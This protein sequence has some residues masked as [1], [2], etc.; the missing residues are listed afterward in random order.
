MGTAGPVSTA[1]GAESEMPQIVAASIY[2]RRNLLTH[3]KSR[4]TL[5]L[6]LPDRPRP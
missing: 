5:C 1:G 2:W 3:R 6:A 4:E